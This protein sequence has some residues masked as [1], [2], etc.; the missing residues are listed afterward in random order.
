[1]SNVYDN[2]RFFLINTVCVPY[3]FQKLYFDEITIMI[4]HYVIHPHF[5]ICQYVIHPRNYTTV[6]IC[7]ICVKIFLWYSNLKCNW[8]VVRILPPKKT[9][10]FIQIPEKNRAQKAMYLCIARAESNGMY[11][12]RNVS[13]SFVIRLRHI[14]TN[15]E[16]YVNIIALAA[17]RVTVTPYPAI[18]RRPRCSRSTE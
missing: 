5:V 8:L 12:C 3:I 10:N 13:L 18:R 15:R 2:F 16:E 17:P 11:R 9:V 14:V 1:M 7:I 6:A 4:R